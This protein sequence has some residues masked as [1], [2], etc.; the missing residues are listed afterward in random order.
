MAPWCGFSFA[1]DVTLSRAD[2]ASLRAAAVPGADT[3]DS[4]EATA[5]CST[6]DKPKLR[7]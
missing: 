6:A 2:T 1:D 4:P 7:R 5:A 3:P